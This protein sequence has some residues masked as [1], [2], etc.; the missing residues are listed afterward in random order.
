MSEPLAN[1]KPVEPG[2][3]WQEFYPH[4]VELRVRIFATLAWFIAATVAAFIFRSPIYEFLIR[5]LPDDIN[6]NVFG[7]TEA[8]FTDIK[9][10]VVVGL[11]ATLPAAI[12]HTWRFIAPALKPHEK[13]IAFSVLPWVLIL[14]AAGVLFT[15][16]VVVPKGLGILLGWGGDRYE[17]ELAVGLYFSFLFGLLFAGGILFELP[18]L[19][20]G[21]AK[22]GW[23][24]RPL[25]IKHFRTAVIIILFLSALLTPSPDAFT[26]FLLAGPIILLYIVS[27]F[28]V[29]A[30][31]KAV[32]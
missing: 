24:D 16:L 9:I 23:V 15:F 8:F 7:V 21:L 32:P 10:A 4:L 29:G 1:A 19:L 11:L 28:L 2:G 30:V 31:R 20:V 14:F 3:C 17:D 22:L 25:L 18:V 26:M 13:R 6:L 12:F 27:I 5:P